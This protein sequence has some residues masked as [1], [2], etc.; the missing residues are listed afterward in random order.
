MRTKALDS[1]N[2]I[3][4][5]WNREK[6][7][8]SN[9]LVPIIAIIVGFLVTGIMIALSGKDPFAA[10]ALLFKG[11]IG[12]S[13]QEII[14]LKVSGEGLLKGAI[15]TLTGLSV[16][17]AFNV[18]LFNIGAEGQ[19]I[20]GAIVA[21]YL[22]FKLNM[23]PWIDIPI[24][25]AAVAVISGLYG[26]L[27]GWLKIKRGVHEVITTI[28]LNWIAINLVENWLVVGPFS[29]EKYQPTSF[30]AGTP[31]VKDAS[32]LKPFFSASRLN[33]S[34][35]IAV[36]AVI[37][38]YILLSKTVLGYEI[39]ATGKNPKAAK[40]AGIN[41]G[42][43]MVTAMFIAGAL[44]GISGA[45]MILGT[46]GRYPGVFR[47]GYGFDGITMAL[48][49]GNGAIGTFFAATFFGLVR[50]GATGMQLM[51]IHKT[52]TD[53]IQGVATLFIAGQIGIKFL[54]YRIGEKRPFTKEVAKS[55][56]D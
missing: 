43:A 23:S 18:G 48:I 42:R 24:I 30:L 13:F 51:G 14:T 21:A 20:V 39:R 52:F 41:T 49:G 29:I 53:I 47:P 40:Y 32:R 11:A 3:L 4:N 44:A 56:D 25:L 37:F 8:L 16:A 36:V 17:V 15:L 27:A 26:A 55:A 6:G 28:M 34:I 7:R 12:G 10:Y 50:S 2:E 19:F 54:L 22:G 38:V 1:S 33:A 9:F 5:W 45:C 31:Y 35:I 46:E